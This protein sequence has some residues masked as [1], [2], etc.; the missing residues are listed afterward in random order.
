M[1]LCTKFPN[2]SFDDKNVSKRPRDLLNSILT[3]VWQG[4]V[5]G[6]LARYRTK[7]GRIAGHLEFGG[8]AG[9]RIVKKWPDTLYIPSTFFSDKELA[10]PL[11]ATL[12]GRRLAFS[13]A[14]LCCSLSKALTFVSIISVWTGL[15]CLWKV[16]NYSNIYI[17]PKL[18]TVYQKTCNKNEVI[19]FN[20]H[21]AAK[22]M[23]TNDKKM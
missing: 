3:R 20:W 6:Y 21:K 1:H 5:S 23:N 8:M 13:W 11:R 10:G 15:C 22:F 12:L 4:I 17:L 19:G 9:Y 16:N 14:M 7:F 2:L 18:A